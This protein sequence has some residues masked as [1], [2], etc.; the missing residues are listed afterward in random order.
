MD[1]HLSDTV[2]FETFDSRR[3]DKD[4]VAR[5]IFQSDPEMNSLVYGADPLATILRLLTT[6]KTFFLPEYT[7]LAIVNNAV[8]GIMVAYPVCR[9]RVARQADRFPADRTLQCAKR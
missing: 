5:L 8:A 6:P 9:S 2:C 3:H 4:A 1:S 7:V